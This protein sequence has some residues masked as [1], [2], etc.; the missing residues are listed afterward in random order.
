MKKFNILIIIIFIFAIQNVFCLSN[1]DMVGYWKI[2][3]GKSIIQIVKKGKS[4]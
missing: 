2:Q 1:N 3:S 4:Y